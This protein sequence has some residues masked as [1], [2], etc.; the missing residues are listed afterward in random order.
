MSSLLAEENNK[1]NW[2]IEEKHEKLPCETIYVIHSCKD[3]LVV[4]KCNVSFP[5]YC[6]RDIS[7][8]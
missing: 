6:Y 8:I 7:L 1:I 2:S 3:D 4:R 5:K